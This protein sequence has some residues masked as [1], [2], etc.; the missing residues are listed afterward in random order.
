[1][2]YANFGHNAMDYASNTRLSSTFASPTQNRF[3]IDGLTWLGGAGGGP[4]P[5]DPISETAWY[6][7]TSNANGTCVDARAAATANGTP[8]QQYTCNGTTAQQFRFRPTDGGHVRIAIRGN[9]QQVVDVTAV[10]TADDAPLQLWSY[11]GGG[12]Q[13]WLP[14]RETSGRYHFTAR[15][16]GKCLSGTGSTANGVQLVQRACDNSAAQSFGLIAHP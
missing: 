16:S 12:N 6:S 3:L 9:P 8:I 10:S 5:S 15:H 2:L 4:A 11:G 1:M 14:V 13:Q 7:L